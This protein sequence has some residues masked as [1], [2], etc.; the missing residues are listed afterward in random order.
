M[1]HRPQWALLGLGALAVVLLFT[2]P[3][4]RTILRRTTPVRAFALASD[5]QREIFLKMSDRNIAATAY[6]A[7]LTPV[8]VPTNDQPE[9]VPLANIDAS[10]SGEFIEIDAVHRAEGTVNLYRLADGTVLL[11][12]ENDFNV[13]NAPGLNV[14]LSGAEAPL[15]K[16]DLSTG[17]PEFLVGPLIGSS[18]SQQFN[19]PKELR[20]ERYKSVVLYSEPLNMIYSSARLR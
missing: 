18:G 13:T 19:V 16:S 1:K 8:P 17:A 7:M 14:Y 12:L 10:L 5:A 4:W 20:L 6:A 11:R 3:F 9:E 2:Y 15:T